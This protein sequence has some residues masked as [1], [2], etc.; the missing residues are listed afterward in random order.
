MKLQSYLPVLGC[1]I[2][3]VLTAPAAE[4]RPA[5]IGE[6]ADPNALFTEPKVLQLKIDLSAAAL[7]ALNKNPKAYVKATVQ[8][9]SHRFNEVAVRLKGHGSF[10]GLDKKP[11][12][13]LKFNEFVP[14][15]KFH[16]VTKLFLNNSAH[17]ASYLAETL[18]G[19]IFREAGVPAARTTFARM[20][21]NGRDAGLYVVSEAMNKDFLSRYFKK[22]KGNL[23]EGSNT[24]VTDML[25]KDSG[26]DSTDQ[27][28][29]KTLAKAAAVA[30]SALRWK[31]LTP[32]LDLERFISFAAIEVLLWHRDGYA[33]E[34]KNYRIYHD[35]ASDQMVFLPHGVEQLFSK[36]EGALWPEWKGLVA[37]AVIETP[38]GK[39]RYREFMARLINGAASPTALQERVKELAAKIRAGLPANEAAK[40]F[41]AAVAKLIE[42]LA[43]RV[44]FLD[45]ELKK[46]QP[47]PK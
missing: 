12:L 19:Q 24:D 20:D 28:D 23:Y 11:S 5:K 44:A 33:L 41:D 10:L 27:K 14:G 38:E 42:S 34:H 47:A 13:A 3:L 6:D 15:Q 29:V 39:Q 25:D 17:D 45:A 30:D 21:F 32:L 4:L 9:G 8:E 43:K 40:T 22:A 31:K 37:G 26:D 2:L 1:L 7:E 35:P 16:G 46:S 36:P 18:A